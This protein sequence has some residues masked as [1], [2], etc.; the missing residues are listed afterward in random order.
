MMVVVTPNGFTSDGYETAV[1]HSALRF[2]LVLARLSAN[3]YTSATP[4]FRTNPPAAIS[5]HQA[6]VAPH[7]TSGSTYSVSKFTTHLAK[8]SPLPKRPFFNTIAT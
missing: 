3:G 7:S 5:P 6:T 1:S 2:S 4:L 8:T